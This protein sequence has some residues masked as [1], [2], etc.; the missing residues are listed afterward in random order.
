MAEYSSRAACG[1]SYESRNTQSLGL[2]L[3]AVLTEDGVQRSALS[4]D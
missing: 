1:L 4:R 3:R 2:R